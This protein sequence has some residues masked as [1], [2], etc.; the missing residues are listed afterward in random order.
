MSLI[1]FAVCV[2]KLILFCH[3]SLLTVVFTRSKVLLTIEEYSRI[4]LLSNTI[5]IGHVQ[6]YYWVPLSCLGNTIEIETKIVGN[7]FCDTIAFQK[8]K[9]HSE[10]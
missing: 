4:V 8:S 9:I 6:Y 10:H 2:N 5:A 3:V 1:N 7:S